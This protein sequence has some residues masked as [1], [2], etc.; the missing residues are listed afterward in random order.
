MI[1]YLLL[2]AYHRRTNLCIDRIKKNLLLEAYQY[3]CAESAPEQIFERL[4]L[5]LIDSETYCGERFIYF[6]L[7]DLAQSLLLVCLRG[8][9]E[10]VCL[11]MDSS[12]HFT[13]SLPYIEQ[14]L[15]SLGLNLSPSE[16]S[17]LGLM[18]QSA[19]ISHYENGKIEE[20]IEALLTDMIDEFRQVAA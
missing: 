7:P 13:E 15:S 6:S 5:I 9:K 14:Q 11:P 12:L 3:Y 16:R 4:R 8:K 2:S 10:S 19:K 18:L 1:R 20:P 17:Y